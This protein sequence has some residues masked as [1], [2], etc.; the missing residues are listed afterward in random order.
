VYIQLYIVVMSHKKYHDITIDIP[1]GNYVN[2]MV[3]YMNMVII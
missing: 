3:A 1:W 2:T